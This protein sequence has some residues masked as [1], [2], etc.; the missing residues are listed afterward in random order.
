MANPLRLVLLCTVNTV[1]VFLSSLAL[2]A[3]D[4]FVMGAARF[5]ASADRSIRTGSRRRNPAA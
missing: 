1:L 3:L 2:S 5:G 4:L